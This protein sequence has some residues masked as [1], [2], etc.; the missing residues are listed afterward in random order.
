[1][2]DFTLLGPNVFDTVYKYCREGVVYV[3]CLYS[4]ARACVASKICDI[5]RVPSLT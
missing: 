3:R 1:M 5:D 2:V 4:L